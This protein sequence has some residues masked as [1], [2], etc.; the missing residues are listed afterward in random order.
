MRHCITLFFLLGI[1]YQLAGQEEA[2]LLWDRDAGVVP[3]DINDNLFVNATSG[4]N[5]LPLTYDNDDDTNW[6]STNPMPTNFLHRLDQNVLLNTTYFTLSSG[7]LVTNDS[8]LTDGNLG[9]NIN[10]QAVNGIARVEVTF[11][12]PLQLRYLSSVG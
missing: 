12:S 5:L 7:N 6:V 2:F 11:N 9:T 1:V 3:A 4:Q 8:L 10:A